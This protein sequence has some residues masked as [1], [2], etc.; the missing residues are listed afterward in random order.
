M[1]RGITPTRRGLWLA[2][3]ALGTLV[4]SSYA[5]AEE[6]SSSRRVRVDVG[7]GTW[8][9]VGETTWSHNASS[10]PPFGNP[11]SKLTYEDHSTNVV[12]LTA[13]VSVGPRWYGRV[14][15]GGANIGGGSL[16]DDDFLAPDGGKPSLRTTSDIDGANMWYVNA[17][18]GARLLN[19]PNGRGVLDGFVGFQYWRQE[20]KAYGVQQQICSSAGATVDLDQTAPGV[21]PLCI[22]GTPPIANSVLAITNVSNWYS[23]RTGIQTEYRLTRWLAVQG[24]AVVKP[25][26]F[27]QNDDTHHLRVA[28]GELRDP[29]F[30]ML[31]IGFGADAE[32]RAKI[33]FSRSLAGYVGYRVWWNRMIDGTWENHLGDGRS[34][35]FPLTQY[36][37]LRHGLTAGITYLF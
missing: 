12:E 17:D 35:S 27:F 34:F 8:I 29:S 20:H 9:S 22:P 5:V 19:F 13:K 23:L 28:T 26:S 3:L 11:T 32:V 37:S 10:Q 7:L 18:A 21:Q 1:S 36:E 33:Y 6:P 16:T 4:C 30:T 2:T 15:L 24:A 14:N 25:I 31:G